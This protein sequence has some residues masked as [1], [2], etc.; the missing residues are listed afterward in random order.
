[1]KPALVDSG[2]HNSL[3]F[4]TKVAVLRLI[5]HNTLATER[6]KHTLTALLCKAVT[7]TSKK[8]RKASLTVLFFLLVCLH[9]HLLTFAS[10]LHL[11]YIYALVA[12][13]GPRCIRTN[14]QNIWQ[15]FNENKNKSKYRD[16]PIF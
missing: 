2:R 3:N 13:V 8:S 4:F 5:V 9:I 10:S 14:E 6:E 12:H 15:S 11:N 16:V 1:M 7:Y